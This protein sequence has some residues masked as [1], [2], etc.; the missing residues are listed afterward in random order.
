MRDVSSD[1]GSIAGSPVLKFSKTESPVSVSP[2]D[3]FAVTPAHAIIDSKSVH[4]GV[5]TPLRSAALSFDMES[6]ETFT[7]Q[8]REI[9]PILL[10]LVAL[11]FLA[12]HSHSDYHASLLQSPHLQL[13][14]GKNLFHSPQM[15]LEAATHTTTRGPLITA[16]HVTGIAQILTVMK[17]S[18]MLMV[19]LEKAALRTLQDVARWVATRV[20]TSFDKI[21]GK[22]LLF[23]QQGRGVKHTAERIRRPS[24]AL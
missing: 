7:E 24:V 20:R 9:L 12:M 21:K 22:A 2:S 4:V 14:F 6:G 13:G 17:T 19:A 23:Q 15:S 18:T 10:F 16:L 3:V 5:A 8:F 1:K 11:S